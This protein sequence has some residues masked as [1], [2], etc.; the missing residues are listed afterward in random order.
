MK[1]WK[2]TKVEYLNNLYAHIKERVTNPAK[3]YNT[4]GKKVRNYFG[5]PVCTKQ[6]FMDF[7][8][9]SKRF[10][11]MF[12]VYKQKKGQRRYAP[13]ID[14]VNNK[15]GY[16]KDNLQFLDLVSNSKKDRL[17][18]WISIKN[19]RTGTVYKFAKTRQVSKFLNQK[20]RVNLNHTRYTNLKTGIKFKNLTKRS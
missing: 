11:Y 18:K 7:A 14:R 2:L 20:G 12:K 13:S 5:L 8:I 4:A 1:N 6:E 15:R 17:V 3:S 9:H 19:V 10:D 16:I